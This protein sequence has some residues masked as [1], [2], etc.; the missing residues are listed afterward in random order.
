MN[1]IHST[2]KQPKELHEISVIVS[3]LWD[4]VNW[5]DF[6]SSSLESR[7]TTWTFR[8]PVASKEAVTRV[9]SEGVEA[10]EQSELWNGNTRWISIAN[11]SDP[12]S[13]SD[14]ESRSNMRPVCVAASIL[15]GLDVV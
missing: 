4:S 3:R 12:F 8:E 10:N 5:A 7:D 9:V 14:E 1:N 13:S 6:E 15:L 11:E 2:L